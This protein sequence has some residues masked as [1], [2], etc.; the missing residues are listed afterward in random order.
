LTPNKFSILSPKRL[1]FVQEYLIDLN[2]AQAAIRAGY[3]KRTAVMQASRLL[4][5]ANV[6]AALQEQKAALATTLGITTER[7]V[8]EYAALGFADMADYLSFDDRGNVYLDWSAMPKG[9]TKAIAEVTQEEYMDGKGEG[10]R[11]VRKTRFKL[12]N[13][14]A[15]LDSLAARLWPAIQKTEASGPN[16]G[17]ITV[18]VVYDEPRQIIEGQAREIGEGQ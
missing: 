7:I 1:R 13:K 18:R 11:L 10:A 14:T 12:Y 9:A 3:S 15:A 6:Q 2:G 16:G 5:N 8:A 4:T 17:P